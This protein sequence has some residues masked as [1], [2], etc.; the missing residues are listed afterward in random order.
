MSRDPLISVITPSFNMVGYLEHCA[1][2]VRSQTYRAY[3]H[4]VIDNDSTDGTQEFLAGQSD[5]VWISEP[6]DG[7]S[8]A[9]NRGF[10]RARGDVLMWLNADDWLLPSALDSIADAHRT[11]LG[12]PFWTYGSVVIAAEGERQITVPP[13]SPSYSTLWLGNAIPQPGSAW[14]QAAWEVAGPLDPSLHFMM[15]FDLWL[16]FVREGVASRRLPKVLAGFRVHGASKSGG[17]AKSR[18]LEEELR[19][20]VRHGLW[21]SSA[22]ALGRLY[23]W[24]VIE[25]Q[26]VSAAARCEPKFVPSDVRGNAAHEWIGLV[27]RNSSVRLVEDA[28]RTELLLA[29]LHAGLRPPG[30]LL[31]LWP[32]K[33]VRRRLSGAVRRAV[34]K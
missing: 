8:H 7:Q 27:L 2:S 28:T 5:L 9:I 1:A 24:Q 12:T 16:R 22:V 14:N 26:G 25:E 30:R 15:D 11:R 10:E 23:A 32:S 17:Q 18:F 4:I 6:D 29:H 34:F 31:K 13:K 20:R 3:E 33:V 19:I 21:E